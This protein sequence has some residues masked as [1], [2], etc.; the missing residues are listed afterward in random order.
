VSLK[1]LHLSTTGADGGGAGRAA[2]ALDAAMKQQGVDSRLQTAS[3]I[4]FHLAQR[5][6]RQLWRLQ[7][8]RIK[9]WR[10]PARFG[11]LS[12]S[13]INASDADVLNLHWV[14]NGYLSIEEI[15]RITKP[16]VWS[17]YDMWAFCGTEHY[18]VDSPD[19]RWRTGYTAHNRPRD[20]SGIDI[21]KHAWE[22]KKR[23]WHSAPVVAASTWLTQAARSSAL[24]GEW[25]VT[26]VPHV[27]DTDA[28]APIARHEARRRLGL[29]PKT[30]LILFLSSAGIGDARK[31]F[32]L[33]EQSLPA[34]KAEIPD[35]AVL[36][37][38]PPTPE[39]T[40]GGGVPILWFGTT[41]DNE[42]LRDLYCAADVT[43][44]PSREDNM[45]LTAMEAQTCGRPVVAFRIGGLPDIVEHNV[46]GYLAQPGEVD[47]LASGLIHAIEESQNHDLWGASARERA[48]ST[49]SVPV[50]ASKYLDVYE[51]ALS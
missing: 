14:T 1:V 37:V 51:Q 43:A 18:G 39:Q 12:A 10:S 23:H 42:Q 8:S 28:F 16:I 45:P 9:T 31:G 2:A 3:G 44:V 48:V 21:D 25:P 27:I 50:V 49:W 47:A 26:T 34:V 38:G 7:R 40:H 22:R 13:Q 5:A 17:L 46:T 24:M 29:N 36:A 19:A 41:K 4:R 11:S 32:N 35:V 33:L 20:E 15:G 30:P 6:D